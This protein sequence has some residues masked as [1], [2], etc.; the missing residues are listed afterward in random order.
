MR[1]IKVR[2]SVHIE[3]PSILEE[4]FVMSVAYVSRKKN[5]LLETVQFGGQ[6]DFYFRANNLTNP[7]ETAVPSQIRRSEDNGRTWAT[8]E[9]WQG[10]IVKEGF[11]RELRWEPFFLMNPATGTLMRLY[12]MC[13]DLVNVLPW[14]P[15]SPRARTYRTW[16]QLSRDGGRTWGEPKAIVIGG[17]GCD[18]VNWA[19]GIRYG[20][21]AGLVEGTVPVVLPDGRFLLPF[22][23]IIP[24]GERMHPRCDNECAALI[25]RWRS[26]DTGVDW[27]LTSYARVEP[28]NSGCGGVEASLAILPDGRLLMLM[29]VV[30]HRE[31][32]KIVPP[33]Q[34]YFVTS[35]DLGRTW[36]R[37]EALRY[38]DGGD[39]YNP[40][41]L[42]HVFRSAKNGRYYFIS[43]MYD[44][45][46]W[47]SDP[48]WPLQIAELD[49]ET[50]RIRRDTVTVI[51]TR[52]EAEGQPETIR[53]SNW[54]RYE[55]RE[56]GNLILLMTGCPGNVGRH[57]TCG[58]PP[59]NFR[60][61]I[62]LPG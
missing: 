46:V 47:A 52:N 29:R 17:Q 5:V 60:Y 41:T 49:P 33:G 12:L 10:I 27:D 1:G 43:N 59:H 38:G 51:E 24:A 16:T 48:R 30:V 36:S 21:N 19:P 44:Q 14:E 8:V 58:V 61:E 15:E 2:K 55:D 18:E 62:E 3:Q 31:E 23:R 37:P 20:T 50:L 6:R 35:D 40:A 39:L 7:R 13:E 4:A 56:T 53:F 11:Q 42:G 9:E 57:E 22:C 26:D 25:G 28:P 32:G 45:P 34:R 54:A